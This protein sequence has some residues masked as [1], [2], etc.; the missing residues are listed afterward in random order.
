[1]NQIISCFEKTD[2]FLEHIIFKDEEEAIFSV[3][4]VSNELVDIVQGPLALCGFYPHQVWDIFTIFTFECAFDDDPILIQN[5]KEL[6]NENGK[7][8]FF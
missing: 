2:E 4:I 7:T 8:L 6:L 5:M 3:L 1:M